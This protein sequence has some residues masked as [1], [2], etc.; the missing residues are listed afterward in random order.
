MEK[1][2]YFSGSGHSRKVAEYFAEK[3]GTEALSIESPGCGLS[4]KG[5][6]AVVVFPVYCEMLPKPV[7]DFLA[8]LDAKYVVLIATYGKICPGNVLRSAQKRVKG[9]V[10]AG[11]YIPT[12]HT[13]LKEQASFE[14]REAEAICA[15]I[16]SP[17]PVVIPKKSGH[18]WAYFFPRWRSRIGVKMK[19]TAECNHCGLCERQ[20]PVLAIHKGH[21]GRKCIRCL[22]CVNECPRKALEFTLHPLLERYLTK[23]KKE[24]TA[25]SLSV[26]L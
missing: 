5:H 8:E 12:G 19:R 21:I 23:Q 9:Q 11:A 3:L 17:K 24:T 20:C 15:R 1:V 10:I 4:G 2:Y 7:K 22:R 26:Y 25:S 18:L 13:Y 6:A 16:R 14:I